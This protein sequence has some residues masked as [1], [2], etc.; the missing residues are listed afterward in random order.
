MVEKAKEIIKE[1][2]KKNAYTKV[3]G[4]Y[5]LKHIEVNKSAAEKIVSLEK[6]IT[7]S[8][9]EMKNEAKKIAING[10]GMLS[11]EE[12]FKI[13]AKYFEFDAIQE[14]AFPDTVAKVEEV[15]K[16]KPKKRSFHVDINDL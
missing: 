3:I 16:E 4:E 10:C 13:V 7:L 11:D 12:A 15:I 1:E 9:D 14:V 5:V 8:L 6:T 2:M